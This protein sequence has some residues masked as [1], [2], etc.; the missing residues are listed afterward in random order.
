M[1]V[2]LFG[3]LNFDVIYRH[4]IVLMV[5]GSVLTYGYLG[6]INTSLTFLLT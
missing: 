5:V 4:V 3:W 1:F 2:F 6:D